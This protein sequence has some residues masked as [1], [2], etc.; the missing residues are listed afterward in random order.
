MYMKI[1][2]TWVSKVKSI[3]THIVNRYIGSSA[4]VYGSVSMA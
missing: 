4:M 1:S 2:S 3:Q